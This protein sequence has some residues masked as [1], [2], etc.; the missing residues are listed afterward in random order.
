MVIVCGV[1]TGLN[2]GAFRDCSGLTSITIGNGVT[3]IGYDA[4]ENCNGLTEIRYNGDF[5]GWCGIGD[6]YRLMSSG[7]STKTLY[8]G[9]TKIEGDLVIPDSVTSIGECAFYECFG[10]ISVTI[11]DSV[12]SI[13]NG[14]FSDCSGLTSITIP[15]S[16]TS[17]GDYAFEGCSGLTSIV[18][19][20]GNSKYSAKDNCLIDTSTA[21]LVLGCQTSVIPTDGSVKRIGRYAFSGC[22]GLTS[23]TIPDSVTSIGSAAFENC[24]GLTSV[25]IGNGVTSIGESAFENCTGL[26]RIDFNG[27]K[28]QWKAIKKYNFW[29]SYTGNFTVYCTDGTLSKS[30]A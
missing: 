10:L 4:F 21:T 9:G 1:L 26:T 25:A 18:V 8:V 3:S 19:K 28:A 22:S 5:T 13:G 6:L 15:D 20:E 7:K 27:T 11:P 14:A 12:T 24:T 23:V 16:V 29:C 2:K 17:I 30:E